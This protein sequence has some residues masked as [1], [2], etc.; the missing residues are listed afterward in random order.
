MDPILSPQ[1][2]EKE[3]LSN[4]FGNVLKLTTSQD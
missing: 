4:P 3:G 1:K 2:D